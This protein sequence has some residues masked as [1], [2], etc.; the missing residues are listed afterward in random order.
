[1]VFLFISGYVDRPILAH[2][3]AEQNSFLQKPI[4]RMALLGKVHELLHPPEG[5]EKAVGV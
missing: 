1:M 2:V 3:I 5:Y 4:S